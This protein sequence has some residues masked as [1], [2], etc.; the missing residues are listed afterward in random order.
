MNWKDSG[1]AWG[2]GKAAQQVLGGGGA[3]AFAL[4]FGDFH[5]TGAAGHGQAVQDL[6]G[7][8]LALGEAGAEEFQAFARHRAPGTREGRECADLAV[9]FHGGAGQSMRASALAILVA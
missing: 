9:D 2:Q 7:G 8:A 5:G 1:E 3:F 4:G 6:A